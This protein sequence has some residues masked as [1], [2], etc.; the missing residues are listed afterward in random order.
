[1]GQKTGRSRLAG[2]PLSGDE[3][4]H[5]DAAS[6][7]MRWAVGVWIALLATLFAGSAAASPERFAIVV[8]NNRAELRSADLRYADDD[9][10]ATHRLLVEAGVQ[11]LLLARFDADTESMAGGLRP[12][13]A[14]R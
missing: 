11:S 6:P 10:V 7:A 9:A 3:P 13:G 5:I 2:V 14:P 4:T 1:M 12:Y 8:G